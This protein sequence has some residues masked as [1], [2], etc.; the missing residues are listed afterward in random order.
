VQCEEGGAG[1]G[2]FNIAF[3][4]SSKPIKQD[5]EGIELVEKDVCSCNGMYVSEACCGEPSGIVYEH[6]DMKLGVLEARWGE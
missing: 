3:C 5:V 4:I 6:P 2:D 1:G